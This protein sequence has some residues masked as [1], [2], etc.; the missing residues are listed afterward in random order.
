[1]KPDANQVVIT[2][3]KEEYGKVEVGEGVDTHILTYMVDDL[4]TFVE[5]RGKE[6]SEVKQKI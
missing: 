1:M 3:T 5:K 6:F 4:E 2:W